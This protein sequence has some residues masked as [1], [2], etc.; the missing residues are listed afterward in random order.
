[1]GYVLT[2]A[3]PERRSPP[4]RPAETAVEALEAFV[5]Y[6]RDDVRPRVSDDA[7]QPV[8]LP[9]LLATA[10]WET[11]GAPAE[12]QRLIT[13]MAD[14]VGTSL[15]LWDDAVPYE[16]PAADYWRDAGRAWAL[17]FE[18]HPPRALLDELRRRYPYPHLDAL[19]HAVEEQLPR[20]LALPTMRPGEWGAWDSQAREFRNVYPDHALARAHADALN[21]GPGADDGTATNEAERDR[22]RR[23]ALT[24]RH[25]DRDSSPPASPPQTGPRSGPRP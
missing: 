11:D 12:R 22:V 18:R 7:G 3:E 4:E 25:L 16:H 14:H 8:S 24:E 17:D 19:R 15:R 6:R 9:V 23:A 21:A 2:S 13:A 5:R 20:Y 10:I 1:M